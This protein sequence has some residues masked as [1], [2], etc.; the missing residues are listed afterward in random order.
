LNELR[1]VFM[2]TPDFAIPSL[3]KIRGSRHQLVGIVTQPDRP[4]GRGKRLA[5]LPVKQFALQNN[6]TPIFQPDSL[7][8]LHFIDSLRGL[9]ADVFVVVA[10]RILPEEI[11]VIPPKGTINLHP[12]LLPKY[13]GAAPVNWAIIQGE[14]TTGVTT[15]FIKK[16]IDAGN[17]IL[18]KE[19]R[20]ESD[21][22]AGSLHDRL[23][24]CGGDLLMES[25]DSIADDR[26]VV[27]KQD[28]RLVTKAPK[29]TREICHL[30]F[31]QPADQVKNWIHGLSPY[32]GA[33]ASL[34]G[35]L[36]KIFRAAVIPGN[37]NMTSE[38]QSGEIVK[39][40]SQELWIACHPGILNVIELQMEGHK[41]LRTEEFLRGF[42]PQVGDMFC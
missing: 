12:S 8:D 37:D 1:I 35:N 40:N 9:Q 14:K 25:I 32:P 13:R 15:I 17:I 41:R 5:A 3:G 27:T 29:L 18:Q 22:T 4:K 2:G 6:I 21:E 38:Y 24:E 7:R 31:D 39:L 20:I 11:F 16:E 30:R 19:I 34:N 36:I 26:V 33:W 10:F 23:A 28:E 42:R